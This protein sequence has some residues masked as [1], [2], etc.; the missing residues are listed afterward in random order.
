MYDTFLKVN[1][2]GYV[3]AQAGLRLCCSQTPEDRFSGNGAAMIAVIHMEFQV[4]KMKKFAMKMKKF[5]FCFC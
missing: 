3:D 2:K 1:N 5:V 4:V